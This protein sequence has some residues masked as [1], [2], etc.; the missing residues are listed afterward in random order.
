MISNCWIVGFIA[1]HRNKNDGAELVFK[2]TR[3]KYYWRFKAPHCYVRYENGRKL[4][5]VPLKKD[6]GNFPPPFFHGRF[7]RER[8]KCK[9]K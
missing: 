1:W 6:L 8:A 7:K 5:F 9:Q 4:E 3:R 2:A